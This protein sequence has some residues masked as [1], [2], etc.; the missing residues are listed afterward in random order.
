M[1]RPDQIE[2]AIACRMGIRVPFRYLSLSYICKSMYVAHEIIS[3][4]E[5]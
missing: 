3:E 1:N 5:R 4:S 2:I